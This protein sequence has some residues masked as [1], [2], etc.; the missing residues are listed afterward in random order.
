MGRDVVCT[1]IFWGWLCSENGQDGDTLMLPRWLW[2]GVGGVMGGRIVID[3][4][5]KWRS[6]LWLGGS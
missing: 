6:R 2:L 3:N 5:G 1:I 4:F